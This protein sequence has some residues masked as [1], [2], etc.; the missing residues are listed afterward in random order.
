LNI[1][2]TYAADQAVS[3]PCLTPD[4]VRAEARGKLL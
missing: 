4:L 3:R 1:A 2:L